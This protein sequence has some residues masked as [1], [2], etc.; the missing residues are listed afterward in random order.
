MQS[1]IDNATCKCKSPAIPSTRSEG[2]V[3]LPLWVF[4]Q[5]SRVLDAKEIAEVAPPLLLKIHELDSAWNEASLLSLYKLGQLVPP[6]WP[7]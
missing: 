7:F 4:D 2:N 1:T 3:W 5:V 6:V